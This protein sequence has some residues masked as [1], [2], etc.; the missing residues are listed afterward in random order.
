M[1]LAH[2]IARQ[3]PSP[4]TGQ[5]L[6]WD[7]D[8]EGRPGSATR[9]LALR[10]TSGGAK[11]WVYTYRAKDT[12]T[13]RRYKIGRFPVVKAEAARKKAEA[14]AEKIEMGADPQATRSD[15]RKAIIKVDKL[16]EDFLDKHVSTLRASTQAGYRAILRAH[17]APAIGRMRVR[18]VEVDDV[19]AIHRKLSR[20][21]KLHQANRVV[22]V[23][24]M[25]FAKAL[26]WKLRLDDKNPAKN[27]ARNREQ[28]R[29]RHLEPEELGR[30]LAA[31]ARHPDKPSVDAIWLLVLTGARRNEVLS[32]TWS[33]LDLDPKRP[34]W[35]RRAVNLKGKR[36]HSLPINN[37]ARDILIAIREKQTRQGPLPKFV[38]PGGG[39]L[40]HQREVGKTWKAVCRASGLD[41]LHLH[42]LRHN[43]ASILVSKG[44]SLPQIGAMLAHASPATTQRYAHMHL[45]PMREAAE[46][47]GKVIT[48]AATGVAAS[49]ELVSIEEGAA[50]V[51]ASA[52]VVSLEKQRR[53]A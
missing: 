15:E 47:V 20:A 52:E 11:S 36:D 50:G 44:A 19:R 30:F 25:M 33:D 16:I 4:A 10:V 21:G 28:P 3:L 37:A 13:Q 26:E 17:V 38:F 7:S 41:N 29:T 12:G 22:A 9:G 27:I 39:G 23:V 35:Y 48:E 43:F 46:T 6:H 2:D 40:G 24:S 18:D 1:Y 34:M 14:L 5:K 49:A 31:L 53:G 8:D 45:D 51:A 42:D 32:M